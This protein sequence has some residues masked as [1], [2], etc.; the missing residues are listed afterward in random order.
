MLLKRSRPYYFIFFLLFLGRSLSV[1][2]QDEAILNTRVSIQIKDRSIN[3]A[4]VILEEKI[5]GISFVFDRSKIQLNK[6][7]TVHADHKKIG[8]VLGQV[9]A[10]TPIDFKVFGTQITLYDNPD[11]VQ[12]LPPQYTISGY[13]IDRKTQDPL[14]G[15]TIFEPVTSRGTTTNIEGF[16]SLSLPKG[17]HQLVCSY[18]GYQSISKVLDL[19]NNTKLNLDLNA[20]EEMEE[21]VVES[22]ETIDS[23]HELNTISSNTLDIQTVKS[24]PNMLGE[25]DVVK[26]M[27][28][29]PGVQSG[30]EGASGLFVRGGGPDQNLFLIDGAPVYN[31]NH[32]FGFVSIFDSKIV[33]K[34]TIIKGGF[35]ARYGGRLS[36][37]LDIHTRTGD[38][39]N[40][41][42]EISVGLLSVGASVEGPIWK[43]RTSFLITGRR[44]WVDLFA[45]PIQQ[46]IRDDNNGI[47][48]IINYY[49]YDINVKIKHKFS[50]KNY[51]VL[52]GYFGDDFLNYQETQKL[53]FDIG[54]NRYTKEIKNEDQLQWGNK[55]VSLHWHAEL[56]NKLFMTT[57][58]TYSNYFYESK[59]ENS[60]KLRDLSNDILLEEEFESEG[61]TPIHDIRGS[62]NFD[63]IPHNKHYIRFGLGYTY[64]MFKPE[65]SKSTFNFASGEA[66]DEIANFSNIHE[67]TAFIEDDIRIGKI[68]KINPGIH[69]AD[70]FLKGKNYFSVQPRLLVNLLVTKNTSIKT[71]YARMSQFVHLLTNPGIGLPT[72]LWL[73]TTRNVPPE[74]SHQWTLGLTQDFPF[75]LEFTVEGFYKIMENLLEYNPSTNF[76]KDRRSWESLVEIGEGE[77]YGGEVLLQ[78]N[79]GKFTGWI[80]Y[81]LAWSWRKFERLNQ[82]KRFPYRYDRRHDVSIA[83]N[84]KFNDNWDAGL[85]WVYGTGHPVTLGLERYTPIQSQV[86]AYSVT[87]TG[88]NTGA[89]LSDI[90]NIV[91]R[92]NFR[93]PPYHRLDVTVNWHKKLKHGSQT[94]SLGIYNVYNQANP[95]I[96]VPRESV[97]GSLKL[98]QVSILPIMPS[99]SYTRRW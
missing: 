26:A 20:G 90:T 18:I 29:L 49:F 69:I 24:L 28:L 56:S 51:L 36:S 43:G 1:V 61:Q 21:I 33:K 55:I 38:M 79:K 64:H 8:W 75:D 34:A 53:N 2:A 22:S 97:D 92:N 81:T 62:I 60:A 9:L 6:R 15:A 73:P 74:H 17:Q 94:L 70:F 27:Q 25:T 67:F 77:S 82:G 4:L 87:Y 23:R 52:N 71:S 42:G 31:A 86:D 32:L 78:R 37:V 99:I 46:L 39:Q 84:Y 66:E 93:M 40:Y 30:S 12:P 19:E 76:L 13:L 35:P 80:S 47:G 85:V 58:A 89:I 83:L 72:D 5:E 65:I 96:I 14:I 16:Y 63:Y 68:L 41:H 98:Y 54:A 50:D 7:I 91:D 10:G 3:A 59:T 45:V 57:T 48:S 11:K 44:S 95:Y 88:I